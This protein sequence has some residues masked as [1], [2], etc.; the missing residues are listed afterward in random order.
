[1]LNNKNTVTVGYIE[2]Y[3]F[4]KIKKWITSL[5]AVYSGDIALI[6][7]NITSET[8]TELQNNNIICIN[9]EQLYK[10]YNLNSFLSPYNT[11]FLAL[12]LC[13]KHNILDYEKYLFTDSTD[14]YFQTN[15]FEILQDNKV[16]LTLENNFYGSCST[17]DTWILVGWGQ[18]KLHT[19]LQKKIVNAGVL[20]ANKNNILIFLKHFAQEMI[21]CLTRHNTY[22]T[23]DQ[24]A[25][26]CVVYNNNTNSNIVLHDQ[27]YAI[28]LSGYKFKDLNI[29]DKLICD[30][31]NKP[32]SIIHQYDCV[33]ELNL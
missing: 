31:D 24:S 19:L 3:N 8:L 5:Q 25:F 18:E 6:Y 30:K 28:H 2:N 17:N 7:K 11:K 22:P 21:H 33:G 4:D 16:H 27:K 29:I 10:N 12:Y 13:I 14:V 9:V 26:N 1:M 15:P 32:F 20:L 23:F